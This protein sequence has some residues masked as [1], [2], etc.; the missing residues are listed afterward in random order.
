MFVVMASLS[1][2]PAASTAAQQS[3][4][5]AA[6]PESGQIRDLRT[7]A[8]RGDPRAQYLLGVRY[9]TGDGVVEDDATA[10]Q[11]IRKAADQGLADA[12]FN[13]GLMYADGNGVPQDSATAVSWLRKAAEQG[14]ARAESNLGLMYAN[15]TGV[16]A[17]P[18][19][20]YNWLSIVSAR[21]SAGE[22]QRA[23]SALQTVAGVLTPAQV[24]E[25]QHRAQL[26]LQQHK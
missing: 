10:A 6:V 5:P 19:E 3:P 7:A 4:A 22:R 9:A 24:A 21:S 15:G 25:A 8:E 17:D 12:Q 14:D 18:L 11:W 26:W 23:E 2:T 20:A 1:V 13:L 16:A